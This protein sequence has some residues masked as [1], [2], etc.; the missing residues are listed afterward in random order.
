VTEPA[1]PGL[2]RR[3]HIAVQIRDT[4]AA[5]AARR[6]TEELECGV[7]P[8]HRARDQVLLPAAQPA[9]ALHVVQQAAQPA[10]LTVSP[11]GEDSAVEEPGR[12]EVGQWHRLDERTG[13]VLGVAALYQLE[14]PREQ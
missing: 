9:Q 14:R 1:N 10:R 5:T 12:A 11:P 8:P 3:H 13:H 7:G 4:D 2:V 6:E